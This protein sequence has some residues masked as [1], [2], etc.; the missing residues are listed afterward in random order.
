[1]ATKA[2]LKT[3]P[4]EHHIVSSSDIVTYLQNELGFAF[5]CDFKLYDNRGPQE[6][7]M[8]VEK[9]FVLMRAVFRTE[10]ICVLHKLNSVA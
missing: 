9:C 10:D 2:N 5:D 3:L 8:A 6:K 1:M 4:I 7:P